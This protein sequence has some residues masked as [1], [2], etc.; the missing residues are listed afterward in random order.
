MELDPASNPILLAT[1]F[2]AVWVGLGVLVSHVGGW[3]SLARVYGMTSGFTGERWMFQ[4]ARMRYWTNYG[5]C[6]TVGAGYEGFY[7]SILF[8]FRI[9]HPPLFIPWREISVSRKKLLGWEIVELRLGRELAIPFHITSR[10][11]ERLQTAAG[12]AW[13][14]QGIG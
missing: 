14:T 8:L 6:L 3:A 2:L 12:S 7:V 11:A 1:V 5:N 10:L 13:P 4:S 9:G